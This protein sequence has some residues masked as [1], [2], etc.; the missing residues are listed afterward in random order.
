MDVARVVYGGRGV[1][2]K[3][4]CKDFEVGRAKVQRRDKEARPSEGGTATEKGK[5][6]RS[7]VFGCRGCA[8]GQSS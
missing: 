1:V 7:F 4:G 6:M 3:G 2:L 5:G 8:I